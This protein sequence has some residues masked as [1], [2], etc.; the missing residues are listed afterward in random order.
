MSDTTLVEVVR[1]EQAES[2]AVLKKIHRPVRAWYKK[3]VD[4]KKKHGRFPLFWQVRRLFF[5]FRY[6]FFCPFR[7]DNNDNNYAGSETMEIMG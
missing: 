2:D 3:E 7:Y 6:V 4:L 5:P 1:E